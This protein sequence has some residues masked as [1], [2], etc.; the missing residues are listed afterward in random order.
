MKKQIITP[1]GKQIL[2]NAVSIFP[3]GS[4]I[5]KFLDKKRNI[6]YVGKA[7]NLKRISSYLNEFRQ[8]NKTKTLISE[9]DKINFIKTP[10]EVDSLILEK[11]L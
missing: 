10:S 4:G 1:Q 9:T 11:I 8:T 5:Y 3:N 6:L 2:R 7:K